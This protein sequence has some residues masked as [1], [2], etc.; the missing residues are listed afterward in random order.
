VLNLKA[1]FGAYPVE[2]GET[3][4]FNAEVPPSSE[5]DYEAASVALGNVLRLIRLN[6]DARFTV[7]CEW[8]HPLL[9]EIGCCP[10]VEEIL[11]SNE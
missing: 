8:K 3:Y 5:P 11:S 6:P 4:P 9:A 7:V 2:L 10:N 1:P